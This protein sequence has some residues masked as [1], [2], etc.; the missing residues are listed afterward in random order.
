MEGSRHASF[1]QELCDIK[2]KALESDI[3]DAK[4]AIEHITNP[5]NGH[6]AIAI[7]SLE[8]KIEK[9]D[10]KINGLI[11]FFGTTVTGLAISIGAEF[12]KKF[13]N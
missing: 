9:V 11:I 2:H 10:A 3:S 7:E 4:E 5:S 6:I 12:I 8:K 1:I 13:V